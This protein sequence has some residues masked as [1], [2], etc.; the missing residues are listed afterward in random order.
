MHHREVNYTVM[1][2]SGYLMKS[3]KKSYAGNP[4]SGSNCSVFKNESVENL[5]HSN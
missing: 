1:L 4:T 3:K 2:C 5:F